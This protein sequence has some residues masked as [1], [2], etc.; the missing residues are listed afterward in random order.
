MDTPNPFD[1]STF[2]KAASDDEVVKQWQDQWQALMANAQVPHLDMTAIQKTQQK[3]LETLA[4]AN[5]DVAKGAQRLMNRQAEMFQYALKEAA[6]A[7]KGL[8]DVKDPTQLATKQAKLVEQAMEKALA[9][10]T[11]IANLMK[12]TQEE[13]AETIAARMKE[14]MEELR[15]TLSQTRADD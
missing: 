12:A 9:N 7:A 3:N 4:T 8:S 1:F 6:E 2:F 11:E 15:Q 10:G 13:T 14:A 5:K